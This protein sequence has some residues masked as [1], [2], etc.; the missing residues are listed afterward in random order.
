MK[1]PI[2]PADEKER[3]S[4]LKSL[5]ILDTPINQH[6]EK[7]TRITQALFK[8]PI[9]AI[10][11]VDDERQWFKS[12]I[13]IDVNRFFTEIAILKP[14]T[15]S[16]TNKHIVKKQPKNPNSSPITEKIKSVCCAGKNRR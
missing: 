1:A 3:L 11:L 9:V 14:N 12:I 4:S 6:F 15:S 13:G 8:V 2:K 5:Q 10:S 16:I 7:I